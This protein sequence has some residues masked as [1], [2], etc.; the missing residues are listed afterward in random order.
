[1]SIS[2]VNGDTLGALLHQRRLDFKTLTSAVKAGDPNAAKAALQSYQQD[3]Q[4]IDSAGGSG[5]GTEL[6]PFATK[7]KTDLS[8]LVSAV[9]SG[10]VADAQTALTA[11]QQDRH[12]LRQG[13]AGQPTDT[14]AL[15]KDLTS[16]ITAIQSGD[17]TGEQTSAAAA[18]K[19]LL[20]ATQPGGSDKAHH[21]HHHH[22]EGAPSSSDGSAAS[23]ASANTVNPTQ[24]ANQTQRLAAILKQFTE[25]FL[26]ANQ[27]T[28]HAVL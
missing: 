22:T 19:D 9:Q 2:G 17:A 8:S 4:A 28:T 11:Y 15:I 24:N 21:H 14:A 26:E 7:I 13:D 6:G 27:A 12:S 25:A 20:A 18:A 1:M 3:V 10:S 16:L 23:D 5:G